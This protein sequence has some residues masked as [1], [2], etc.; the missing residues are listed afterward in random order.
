MKK[1]S[2]ETACGAEP[3]I[4]V[5]IW[6]TP[7]LARACPTAS[8]V[9]RLT[10]DLVLGGVAMAACFTSVQPGSR[11]ARPSKSRGVYSGSLGRVGAA[12]GDGGRLGVAYVASSGAVILL[13]RG[14]RDALSVGDEEVTSL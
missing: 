5:S 8:V 2:P 4:G 7:F 9:S 14:L 6:D 13:P 11:Q 12:G 10:I 3:S 1:M